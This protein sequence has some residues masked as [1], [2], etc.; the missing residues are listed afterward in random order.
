[1]NWEAIG[2]VAELLGALGVIISL[3]YLASD[4]PEYPVSSHVFPPWNR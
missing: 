3:V 4:P 2:A 1:M